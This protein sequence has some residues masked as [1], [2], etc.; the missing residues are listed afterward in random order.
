MKSSLFSRPALGAIAA[1]LM[2]TAM[3]ALVSPAQ[4]QT[5]KRPNIL[6]LMTDR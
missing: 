2:L 6:M 3:P 4:A 1:G 5:Q